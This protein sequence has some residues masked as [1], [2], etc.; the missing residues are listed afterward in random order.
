M[1]PK[2]WS[3]S[4]R[5]LTRKGIRRGKCTLWGLRRSYRRTASPAR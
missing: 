5:A 4:R 1:L 2:S 3:S